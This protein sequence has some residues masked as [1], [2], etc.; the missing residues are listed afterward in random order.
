MTHSCVTLHFPLYSLFNL[1]NTGSA[2]SILTGF[3][4]VNTIERN[5]FGA[6]APVLDRPS[7]VCKLGL[8]GGG[9]AHIWTAAASF[10]CHRFYCLSGQ[11]KAPPTHRGRRSP[12][13]PSAFNFQQPGTETQMAQRY[14]PRI[15]TP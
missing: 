11:Q 7:T 4:V 14:G 3:R 13:K 15:G 1:T 9:R 2:Q 10:L 6:L 12:N 8:F 5:D